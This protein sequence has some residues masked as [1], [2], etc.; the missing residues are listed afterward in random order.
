M[1]YN[2]NETQL[3]DLAPYYTYDNG[4]VLYFNESYPINFIC[5]ATTNADPDIDGPGVMASFITTAWITLVVASVPAYYQS[6]GW[7]DKMKAKLR[8]PKSATVN[9]P[10]VNSFLGEAA[11]R[12]LESLCDLQLFTGIAIAV[13]G[14]SQIPTI[15]FYHEQIA[16]QY[17]WLTLNSFWAARLDY[18]GGDT[19]V[20]SKRV[21]VRRAGILI[22]VILG[23]ALQCCINVRES[24]GWDFLGEGACYL[25]HDDSSTWPWVG[26]ASVYALSLL[27]II[28]PATRPWVNQY[29]SL[30]DYGQQVLIEWQKTRLSAL[31]TGFPHPSPQL[32]KFLSTALRIGSLSL[33]IVSTS[34]VI[35]YWLISQLLS[36]FAY[37]DGFGPLLFV[38]YV[39]FG[40]WNTADIVDLKLSNGALVTGSQSRLGFGQILPLVLMV[41]IGYAAVDALYG[42]PQK[43]EIS[44]DTAP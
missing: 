17:W 41:A 32:N 14:L 25:S 5:N 40:T 19:P 43:Q 7:L 33:V 26:G 30:L 38:L 6:L 28:I 35:L 37:G 1:S 21:T 8:P 3:G 24:R 4:T 13:A 2:T 18:M 27:L 39:A 15:S 31:R 44:S 16:I 11:N 20:I 10:V 12:L 29:I 36:I 22:S 9:K 34:S 42:V 23:L